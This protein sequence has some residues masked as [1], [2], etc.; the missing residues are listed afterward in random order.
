[1]IELLKTLATNPP[2]TN[3]GFMAAVLA[4]GFLLLVVRRR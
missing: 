4:L 3:L 2:A 1:M